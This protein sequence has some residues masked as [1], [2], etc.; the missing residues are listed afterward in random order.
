MHSAVSCPAHD[1]VPSVLPSSKPLV[2]FGAVTE[3]GRLLW[4]SEPG[5]A[6]IVKEHKKDFPLIPK[7]SVATEKNITTI[8]YKGKIVFRGRTK[9]HVKGL[10]RTVD[11]KEYAA[12]FDGNK[13]LW[14]NRSGAAEIVRGG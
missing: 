12:A 13:L 6:E 3:D 4:E 9:G 11:K 7:I 10:S 2:P 5:A 1:A 8:K 14:E